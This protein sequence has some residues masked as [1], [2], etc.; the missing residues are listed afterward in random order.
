[1]E[2]KNTAEEPMVPYNQPL[3]FQQVWRMFQA[4]DLKFQETDKQFKETDRKIRELDRLLLPNGE[5][6]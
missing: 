2:D 3:D 5:N 4:T 6:W 1:M